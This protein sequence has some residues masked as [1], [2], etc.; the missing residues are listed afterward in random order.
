MAW[1][2]PTIFL[3]SVLRGKSLGRL[4]YKK[5]NKYALYLL[6][7]LGQ[8][9]FISKCIVSLGENNEVDGLCWG[10][11]HL[12]LTLSYPFSLQSHFSTYISRG[13]GA[14]HENPTLKII[15]G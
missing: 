8:V 10:H 2:C 3:L 5:G 4:F 12:A 1:E 11:S 14:L 13:Q 7:I 9:T 15:S 6:G